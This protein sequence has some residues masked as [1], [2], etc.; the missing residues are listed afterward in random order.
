MN[1]SPPLDGPGSTL[2]SARRDSERAFHDRQ[3][4]QRSAT[5]RAEPAALRF[6]DDAYLDHES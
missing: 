3:A 6:S 2:A 5:F 1:D 4:G